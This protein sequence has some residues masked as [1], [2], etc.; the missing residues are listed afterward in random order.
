MPLVLV[1]L[2]PEEIDN[3][4]ASHHVDPLADKTEL[5]LIRLLAAGHPVNKMARDLSLAPRSVY[6][7]LAKLR[8]RYRVDSNTELAAELVRA[9]F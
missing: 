2:L 3:L 9:G 7:R 5:A 4:L 8:R 6:R 1:A